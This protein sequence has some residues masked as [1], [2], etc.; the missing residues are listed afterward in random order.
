VDRPKDFL[1]YLI[2][3]ST[4]PAL[5]ELFSL[6]VSGDTTIVLCPQHLPKFHPL[7]DEAI[8]ALLQAVPS[9]VLVLLAPSNKRQWRN[10]LESRWKD[11]L[12][13]DISSRILWLGSLKSDE[14]LSMLAVGDIMLDPYPFGGGVTI[15]ESFA[16]STP[17]LTL[18]RL[19]RVLL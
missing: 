9:A 18:P 17:I 8:A 6:K 15:L 7:F 1:E 11:T 2:A 13:V 4:L 12:G 14:Y 3:N 16:M 10:T 19:V 5:A